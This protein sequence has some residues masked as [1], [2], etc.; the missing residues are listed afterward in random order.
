VKRLVLG[1]K[2][3]YQTKAVDSKVIDKIKRNISPSKHGVDVW[4]VYDFMYLDNKDIPVL[5]PL[6]INIPISSKYTIES[7]S[8][9]LYLNTF[10]NKSFKDKKEVTNSLQ[11]VF[12]SILKTNIKIKFVN[13]YLPEPKFISLNNLKTSKTKPNSVLKFNGFR[14]ICP[15]TSQP[16][17]A[18]IYI[19]SGNSIDTDWIINYLISYKDHGDFHEKC[20][21]QIFKDVMAKYPSNHL[22]ICGRFQRRGGIDINPIRGTHKRILFGNFREFNQ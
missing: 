1:K 21:D 8:M 15:V 20:I 22:E 12:K 5:R 19:Y 16:D 2:K 17:F 4:N 14:S 18:N 6:E 13:N 9:K 11:G 10:Y 3:S 7:K